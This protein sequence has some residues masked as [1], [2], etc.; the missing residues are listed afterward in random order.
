M[1]KKWIAPRA[2]GID[3]LEFI[4]DEVAA[5]RAGE[6][7]I[8]VR[9]AGMN[10]AD[11]KHLAREQSG[12]PLGIGYEVAG[13]L[14]RLGPDTHIASGGGATGDEVLAFR[15]AGGY[16][17]EVTV[18]ASD[19]FAKPANLS[20]PQ[21]ANLLLAGT[22]AAEMLELTRVGDGDVVLLHGASG[23]VGVSAVQQA[24]WRGARV[25]GTASAAN[26]DR[27]R[28]FGA[29]AVAYGPGLE[30][31]VRELAPD[32]VDAVLDAVGTD[33]AVDVSVALLRVATRAVTIVKGPK[34][35]AAGFTAIGG[36]MPASKAFRDNARAGLIARAAAGDLAVPVALTF[37][38]SEAKQALRL[39]AEGHPGGKLALIP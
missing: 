11:Y 30:A 31:R 28:S 25:I 13:V 6:V 36:A 32:G 3:V 20:F 4:D 35:D 19:V 17:S 22:T 2:G 12:F 27:V 8:Q 33:E 7:T 21:A 38:L 15:V 5:P 10:P 14:T 26:L 23:A 1:A 29:E 34:T 37:E 9:A 39:L 24:L 18:P 16:A